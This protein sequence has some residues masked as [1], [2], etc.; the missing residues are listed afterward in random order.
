MVIPCRMI[1]TMLLLQMESPVIVK[2]TIRTKC[3]QLEH[4]LGAYERPARPGLIHP[5]AHQIA[6]GP[7]NN[8]RGDR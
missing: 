2:V 5:I 6:T 4:G 1:A 8:A 3:A 7:L